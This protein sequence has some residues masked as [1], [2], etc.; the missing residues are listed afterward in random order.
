MSFEWKY[1]FIYVEI[2]S[3]NC[4]T[5]W[6]AC[7]LQKLEVILTAVAKSTIALP[8]LMCKLILQ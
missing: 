1:V 6:A 5:K 3:Y 7:C 8:S 2:C 4:I